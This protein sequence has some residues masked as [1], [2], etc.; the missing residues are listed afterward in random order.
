MVLADRCLLFHQHRCVML[1]PCLWTELGASFSP[2]LHRNTCQCDDRSW[3]SSS[4][5]HLGV[6]QTFSNNSLFYQQP[7]LSGVYAEDMAT[8][9]SAS[10]WL[11][12][13]I[14]NLV[15]TLASKTF[16]ACKKYFG[17]LSV[18]SRKFHFIKSWFSYY[19]AD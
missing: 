14:L 10:V 15:K 19:S 7:Y 6:L 8:Y 18:S 5:M 2:R 17:S 9:Q 12:F 11:L 4:C 16:C 1:T 13:V 3:H